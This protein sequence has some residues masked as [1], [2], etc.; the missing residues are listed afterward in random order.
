[1]K[2]RMTETEAS[3]FFD[4]YYYDPEYVKER[5]EVYKRYNEARDKE[6]DSLNKK[7]REKHLK[8]F[9]AKKKGR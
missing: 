1:M 9:M 6:L 4:E 3:S 8:D 5:E 7:Y 2:M